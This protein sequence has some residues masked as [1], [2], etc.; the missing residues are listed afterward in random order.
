MIMPRCEHTATRL[1]DGTVLVCGG[2]TNWLY[3]SPTATSEVYSPSSNSWS[4]SG[5]MNNT[6][7]SH[8]ATLLPNGEVLICGGTGDTTN[9]TS[10]VSSAELYSPYR[11]GQ[12][13]SW[14][15]V[16]SMN[17]AR[18]GHSATLL[19]NGKVLV[20]GGQGAGAYPWIL[21]SAELFD[22]ITGTWSPT[23]SMSQ[24][25]RGHTATLLHDGRVLVAG[26]FIGNNVTVSTAEVFDPV[27][28]TWSPVASMNIDRAIHWAT[29]LLDGR[30]IVVGGW[31]YSETGG[32][33]LRDTE[34][35]DP[36]S[37]SWQTN[38]IR[39]GNALGSGFCLLP[40]GD[41]LA[42]A[43]YGT[44]GVNY[45]TNSE[46]FVRATG[47]WTNTS[48]CKHPRQDG[49]MTMLAGGQIVFAGGRWGANVTASTE[50]FESSSPVAPPSASAAVLPTG[51]IQIT[52]TNRPGALFQVLC[53]PD[54]RWPMNQ[55]WISGGAIE[56]LPGQFTFIDRFPIDSSRFYRLVSVP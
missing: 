26:G 32:N 8:T 13:G 35:Y 11:M 28:G 30:V 46:I 6:R 27:S 47:L 44:F 36:T 15:S 16:G 21:A 9:E 42:A 38:G 41:V 55:W 39:T 10:L 19:L 45:P 7:S 52:F 3:F 18:R 12:G 51:G 48:A 22:S 29:M 4:L 31:Q 1:L 24:G 37:G 2:E 49:T 5:E 25:R 50:R 53:S 34:I 14:R 17:E 33:Y 56:M 54:S 23:G 20:V 43:G 40:N